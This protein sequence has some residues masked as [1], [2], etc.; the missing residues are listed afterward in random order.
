MPTYLVLAD[1]RLTENVVNDVVRVLNDCARVAGVP[2]I[3]S[4]DAIMHHATPEWTRGAT[5]RQ[6]TS[7]M[8]GV[9]FRGLPLQQRNHFLRLGVLGVAAPGGPFGRAF[10]PAEEAFED[11]FLRITDCAVVALVVSKALNNF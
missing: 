6:T 5:L 2:F 1:S 9:R 4:I 10:I 7:M 3:R 11:H 8:A